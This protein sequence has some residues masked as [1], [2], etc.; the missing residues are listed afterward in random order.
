MEYKLEQEEDA[1]K[2]SCWRYVAKLL[3]L[4]PAYTWSPNHT[5]QEAGT[6]FYTDEHTC[7]IVMS[8]LAEESFTKQYLLQNTASFAVYLTS[9]EWRL[10]HC[11]TVLS[12][13]G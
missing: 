12:R 1:D 2:G 6:I 9:C 10:L 8:C 4:F 5:P 7:M 3:S 13:Q 11:K